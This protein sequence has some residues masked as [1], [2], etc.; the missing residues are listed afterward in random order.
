VFSPYQPRL[1]GSSDR[2]A[3]L[4]RMRALALA[5]GLAGAACAALPSGVAAQAAPAPD[6]A[7]VDRARSLFAEGVELVA[8][9]QFA[10]AEV[11]FRE[12]LSL[13][14]A[15]AIRY[16]L[17]SVLY[18]Q[19][20]YPEANTLNEAVLA[21]EEA[22]APVREA[23]TQLRAQIAERAGY[24]RLEL[25]GVAIGDVVTIDDYTIVNPG[26]E[27]PVSP[28]P[29]VVVV[30]RDGVEIAR[31]ELQVDQGAHRVVVL[32]SPT[33]SAG[34][35]GRS[36]DQEDWFWPVIGGSAVA[37]VVVIG[38]VVGVAATSGTEGPVEGNFMPGV[39]RW[40]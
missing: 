20:E 25:E 27:I 15:P 11:R 8:A 18:E 12:A 29:H 1:A 14:A 5:A 26:F 23:A 10:E 31:R 13:R 38:V 37:V 22:P 40:P 21:D 2:R 6:V 39:I 24:A 16:N 35:P 3:I 36:I 34:V 33:E 4:H 32:V 9:T 30:T 17:A 19:G 7:A 28:A